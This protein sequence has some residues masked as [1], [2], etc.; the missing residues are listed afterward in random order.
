MIS[1]ILPSNVRLRPIALPME[2]GGWGFLFEPIVLGLALAPSE[3]GWLLA[4][5]AIAAFLV[6]QPLKVWWSDVAAGRSN[7]RTGVAIAIALAYGTIAIAS[8]AVALRDSPGAVV[9]LVLA[10]PLVLALVWFD[11]RGRSRDVVP[12]LVAPVALAAVGAGIVMLDGW[13]LAPA[14]AV[15]ALLSLRAVPSVLYVRSRLR[16]TYGRATNRAVPIAAHA[17]A[18]AV[19]L[20]L[21]HANLVPLAA[22][23]IYAL[24]LLRAG[25]GLSALRRK[26]SAKEVGFAEIGWGAL[27]VLSIAL[28]FRLG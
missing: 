16:L 26:A 4:L 12:E 1:T 11:A 9:P 22:L 2:H 15:W 20:W 5:A 7:P 18:I 23:P 8:F 14:I 10:S 25:V 17:V 27:T 24:L 28:A 13:T 3:K 21:S 19:A 6:R